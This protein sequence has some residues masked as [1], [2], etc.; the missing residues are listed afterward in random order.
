VVWLP[1]RPVQGDIRE[2][3]CQIDYLGIFTQLIAIIFLLIPISGGGSSF[4][5]NSAISI[6]FIVIGGVFFC[7]FLIIEGTVAKHP[8][9]PL[10]LFKD[11]SL[12]LLSL[13]TFCT[14]AY[15]FSAVYYLPI[16]FQNIKGIR[17]ITSSGYIQALILPQVV[18][19]FFSGF[20]LSW[21][22]KYNCMLWAGYSIYLIGAGLATRFDPSSDTGYIIGILVTEGLG[23]GLTLQT[24]KMILCSRK[25]NLR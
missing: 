10:Y 3:L 22:G 17:P 19:I 20:F 13:A 14:G 23:M 2:K 5:W 18:T 9:V 1:L 12:A 11:R 7:L 16:F 15:F 25:V 8:I 6:A 21:H 4:P 24:C